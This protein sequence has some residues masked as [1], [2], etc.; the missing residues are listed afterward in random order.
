M[1]SG[2]N[3]RTLKRNKQPLFM[4]ESPS[5]VNLL[6]CQHAANLA[7]TLRRIQAGN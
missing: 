7:G 5:F 1:E 6:L 3:V 2:G 4:G